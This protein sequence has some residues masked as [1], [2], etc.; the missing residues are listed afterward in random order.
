MTTDTAARPGFSARIRVLLWGG[1]AVLLAVPAVAMLFSTEV[2]WGLE[3]FVAAAILLGAAG[4]ALEVAGR[5][6]V[7]P[8]KR[9][10][11]ALV[12]IGVLLLAWAELAVG[13]VG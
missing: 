1:I 6:L 4:L 12:I 11:A 8:G 3:D 13:I 10:L 2:N 9:L 5:M 7:T